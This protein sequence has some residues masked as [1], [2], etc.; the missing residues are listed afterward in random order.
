MDRERADEA[1]TPA[2]VLVADSNDH[3]HRYTSKQSCQGKDKEKKKY[4]GA[5][6]TIYLPHQRIPAKMVSRF[7]IDR[8]I[9][10]ECAD[11]R[12]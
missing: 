8:D 2:S 5:Q 7:K 3:S 6:S 1:G 11:F 12:D 4:K 9:R 10:V